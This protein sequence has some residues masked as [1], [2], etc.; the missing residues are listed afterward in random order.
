MHDMSIPDVR[1][2]STHYRSL[3]FLIIF[4]VAS[5]INGSALIPR[6]GSEEWGV[7]AVV[8]LACTVIIGVAAAYKLTR[9]ALQMSRQ[10]LRV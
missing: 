6:A 3:T 7:T 9:E 4:T 8:Q 2:V 10:G 1:T 5:V